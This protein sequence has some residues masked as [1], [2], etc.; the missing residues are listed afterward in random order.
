M[1]D[2]LAESSN[3]GTAMLALKIGGEQQR[4][5]LKDLGLMDRVPFELSESARPQIQDRWIDLTTVTVSY[6][7]G[8]AVDAVCGDP[9]DRQEGPCQRLWR[10]G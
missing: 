2:I 6:G 10:Y 4:K 1:P 9:W 7:H 3:R 5:Y 8:M